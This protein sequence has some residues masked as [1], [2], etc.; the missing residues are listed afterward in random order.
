[1][2]GGGVMSSRISPLDPSSDLPLHVAGPALTVDNPPG[3]ILA[4]LG[5][6]RLI[7]EG[8]VIVS[9][10]QGYQGCA[11]AGDR[12]CGMM[13]NCGAAGFVTDGPMRDHAG[14]L[15]VGL[16]SWCTGL[17][18]GSPVTTGPG[19][20]GTPVNIGGQ[21]VETGDMIVADRDGVVIVPFARL[22][23]VIEQLA[24]VSR[25]ETELDDE[26]ADGLQVPPSILE[27]LDSDEV[28]WE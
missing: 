8:D 7:T 12:V 23:A 15:A 6:L 17:N 20:V 11:A 22:D 3:D 1:M 25:L 13:K 19:R 16:A 4:L 18:P 9:A 24:E 14:L 28:S 10:F 27:L 2:F 26:V 5:A 21:H